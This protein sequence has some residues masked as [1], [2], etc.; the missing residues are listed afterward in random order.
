[1]THRK[2]Q[3]RHR[4]AATVDLLDGKIQSVGMKFIIVVLF[5]AMPTLALGQ[6]EKFLTYGL[7][8]SSCANWLAPEH[9]NS[10]K[11]WILGFWTARNAN[12]MESP[13]VGQDTDAAGILGEVTKLCTAEPAMPLIHAVETTYLKMSKK[14]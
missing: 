9:V 5:L 8:N 1:M 2:H 13:F 3:G 4:E 14:R 6:P 7:G 10:G 11:N 12:N